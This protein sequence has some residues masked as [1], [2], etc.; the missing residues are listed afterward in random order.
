MASKASR[1]VWIRADGNDSR[2]GR[3]A[4]N[5]VLTMAA[6]AALVVA[7]RG[8]RIHVVGTLDEEAV[9]PYGTNGVTII[10]DGPRGAATIAPAGTNKT[11][12]TNHGIDVALINLGLE[13][14]GTGG[15]LVNTG[16]RLSGAQCK[17]EGGALALHLKDGAN[18]QSDG[19][20]VTFED[21][22]IA[23]ATR[24]VKLSRGF[25]GAVT[26][27]KFKRC[28]FHNLSASHM[29]D[30][31]GDVEG[32]F[33][34]LLVAD[35]VFCNMEGGAEPTKFLLLNGSNA[36]NGLVTRCTFP[37]A[38]TSTKNL[39]STAVEWVLNNHPAGLSTGQ[40]S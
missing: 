3:S 17:I 19:A 14:D 4:A 2:A 5:A 37:V 31:D 7:Y 34:D 6:A 16:R 25:H 29:E 26:Q 8:D 40:P 12:L 11:A 33:R 28:L 20:D 36:N 23:W 32:L 22:E 9:I 24:G 21:C 39:V 1:D 38:L 27:A 10:G 30:G 35:S 18:G 13:G 15:G